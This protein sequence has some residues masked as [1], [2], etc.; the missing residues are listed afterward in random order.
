MTK[1]RVV[2]PAT[3]YKS[4]FYSSAKLLLKPL[5]LFD[6]VVTYQIRLLFTTLR[7]SILHFFPDNSTTDV[8]YSTVAEEGCLVQ[9][10][11]SI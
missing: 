11:S 1:V 8:F 7:Y 10:V 2:D 6:V 5:F 4:L 9:P 3:E